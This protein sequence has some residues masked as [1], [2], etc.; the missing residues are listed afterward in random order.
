MDRQELLNWYVKR[1]ENV[2]AVYEGDDRKIEYIKYAE[3]QLEEVKN[4][5][6]W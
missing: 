3:Q 6:N 5:R 2:K 4:G 1:L